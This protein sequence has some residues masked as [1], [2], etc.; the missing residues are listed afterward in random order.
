MLRKKFFEKVFL[1][2]IIILI[3][4]SP[5]QLGIA[6]AQDDSA[7]QAQKILDQLSV[8]EKVGQ[9]FYITLPGSSID[10]IEASW[11]QINHIPLGGIYLTS[12][13]NNFTISEDALDSIF[14]IN[15]GLQISAY[16]NILQTDNANNTYI[17]LF[18]GISLENGDAAYFSSLDSALQFPSQ[19]AIGATWDN[20]LAFQ[21]GETIGET[22]SSLGFNLYDGFS[23]DMLVEPSSM[24]ENLIGTHSFGGSPSWVSQLGNQVLSGIKQASNNQIIVVSSN[25]PE[26]SHSDRD[27]AQEIPTIRRSLTEMENVE[28]LPYIALASNP[29]TQID[30]FT[31]SPVRYQGLKGN[32]LST[33]KPI[34]FDQQA[35]DSFIS[36]EGINAWKQSNGIL[37][38]STLNSQSIRHY[39]NPLG[40]SF[41]ASGIAR[42]ALIA[43]NDVLKFEVSTSIE[44]AL[45]YDEFLS[46]YQ[47]FVQKY[48]EDVAFAERVDQAV[49][50]ILKK[51]L[52]IY[53][54]FKIE[55]VIKDEYLGVNENNSSLFF[56]I[57]RSAFSLISPSI[58][59]LESTVPTAPNTSE[60]ILIFTEMDYFSPCINCDQIPR[61]SATQLEDTILSLYGN[62]GPNSIFASYINSY[63]FSYLNTLLDQEQTNSELDILFNSSDWII[64]LISDNSY[65]SN[66]AFSRLLSQRPDLLEQKKSF[67]FSMGSPNVLD[68]T[69]V[70][71]LTAYYALYS[72]NENVIDIAARTLFK[73]IIPLGISP[74]SVPAMNYQIEQATSPNSEQTIPFNI[75]PIYTEDQSALATQVAEDPTLQEYRVGDSVILEIGPIQDLNGNPLADGTDVTIATTY[76]QEGTQ[77]FNQISA[78]TNNGFVTLRYMFEY[79]GTFS[80]TAFTIDQASKTSDIS[81][82]I[83]GIGEES[84][85]LTQVAI[86]TPNA[87][88]TLSPT[89]SVEPTQMPLDTNTPNIQ[90]TFPNGEIIPPPNQNTNF[91]DWLIMLLL[92]VFF[93]IGVY[94]IWASTGNVRWAIRSAIFTFL[95]DT[96]GISYLS[97]GLPGSRFIIQSIRVW[98]YVL[99]LFLI[100]LFGFLV[101]YVRYKTRK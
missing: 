48:N 23:L 91:F 37:I 88:E 55:N 85:A 78:K 84:P 58:Q 72:K 9:L 52:S 35:L 49:L 79:S 2:L 70:S 87:T 65:Q 64:F 80:I 75:T 62:E 27:P 40:T 22:F 66:N 25:F 14:E 31:V 56:R 24:N 28:L 1:A 30:G 96:A 33:T 59:E 26:I 89:N 45:N 61:V 8:E 47:F 101:T 21:Y 63:S 98:G 81:F 13:N 71:K 92:S 38:T 6:H 44:D 36:I 51:K 41:N 18:L 94:T 97:F 95:L 68:A 11:A 4:I 86:N 53:P 77:Y 73:E 20:D 32:I 43:G 34:L 74:I 99:I 76:I 54:E 50:S 15:N 12:E 100:S 29:Y 67:A 93:G 10:E 17:P 60:K 3:G 69:A 5:A 42:D 90:P 46:I 39:D 16:N 19:M 57:N 83:L 82:Y 7:E